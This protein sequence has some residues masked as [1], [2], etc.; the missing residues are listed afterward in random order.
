M[1]IDV[2]P[3]GPLQANCF[4]VWDEKTGEAI[5]IDPGDEPDRIMNFLEENR[6]KVKY[7]LCTHAH[8]DHVGAVPELKVKTG[9]PVAIHSAEKEIYEGARDMAK[10]FGYD[11]DKLPEPD[12]LLKDNDTLAVGGIEFRVLHTPGHSPGGLCLYGNGV[13]FTGDTVFAGSVGRTDFY[14]GSINDLKDSFKKILSLPSGTR[15]LPGHG[16][17]TTVEEELRENPFAEEF[18]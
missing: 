5:V 15:I 10:F 18:L 12:I 14:G 1:M 8:F 6:L 9:A 13:I 3:V 11:I 7:I 4:I 17:E 16:P 2:L